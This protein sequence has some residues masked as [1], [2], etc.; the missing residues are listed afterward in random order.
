MI[1]LLTLMAALVLVA[2]CG[3]K[4]TLHTPPPLWGDPDRETVE[5][6]LPS[7][8]DNQ[9]DQ[10]IFTRHDVDLFR[11]EDEDDDPFAAQ[12]AENED[13]DGAPDAH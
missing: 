3:L 9:Q 4:G 11:N 8:G 12:D 10:V 6:D 13:D 5:R 7:G 1:R 2:G